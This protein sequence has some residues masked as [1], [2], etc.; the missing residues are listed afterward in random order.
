MAAIAVIVFT[1]HPQDGEMLPC[2]EETGRRK[3]PAGRLP[4]GLAADMVSDA[5]RPG[6]AELLQGWIS[7]DCDYDNRKFVIVFGSPSGNPGD[8]L[9]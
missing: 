9:V 5:A 2:C 6:I 1:D 3:T 8:E 7:G 4:I